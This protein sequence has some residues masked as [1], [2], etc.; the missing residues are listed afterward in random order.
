MSQLLW[1]CLAHEHPT[2]HIE[3]STLLAWFH[4]L[5][6]PSSACETVIL[7]DLATQVS[8]AKC[9]ASCWGCC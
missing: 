5:I 1:E 4:T 9:L 8:G 6:T 2:L 3:A 7:E